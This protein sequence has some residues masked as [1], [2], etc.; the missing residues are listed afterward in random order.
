[1]AVVCAAGA[2]GAASIA[3]PGFAD[4]HLGPLEP[5]T[6]E[7]ITSYNNFYEFGTGKEDPARFAGQ[8]TTSPWEIEVDG[9]VDNPC[10]YSIGELIDGLAVGEPPASPSKIVEATVS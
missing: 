4:G 1:M 9:L 6:F 8:L 10:T 2:A 7:E 5:N 3:G